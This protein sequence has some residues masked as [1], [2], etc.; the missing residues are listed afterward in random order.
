MAGIQMCT[1]KSPG[2]EK[3]QVQMQLSFEFSVEYHA[4][5]ILGDY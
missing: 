3:E 2:H 1:G 4:A 5:K